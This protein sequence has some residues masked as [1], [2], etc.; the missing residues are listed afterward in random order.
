MNKFFFVCLT[1][2]V[3]SLLSSAS[4]QIITSEQAILA[5]GECIAINK[6]TDVRI[7]DNPE[8]I[9]SGQN[10]L[11]YVYSLK[12]EG[13]IVVSANINLP[14]VIAY[15]FENNFGNLLRGNPLFEMLVTDL[16]G[17]LIFVQ[18]KTGEYSEKNQIYWKQILL[19]SGSKEQ[20]EQWPATGDGWLKTNWTQ[21]APYNNMCPMDAVSA[22]R[23]IAGCPA[24]AMAQIVNFHETTNQTIFDDTDDY[25][26][27]Y[28][29]RQYF[30]DDDYFT[31][32]FPS[33][34]QLNEYLDTLNSHWVHH[35]LLDNQDKAALTFACG[36]ACK[37]VYTSS[38]SG[39]FGVDQ[40]YD[41]YLRFGFTTVELLTVTDTS[42]Y[43]RL[44]Q[45]IKDTLPGHLAVVDS[46][47][48]MGH[49]V[50]VDGYNEDGYFHIN[51]G[52]G[53]TYNGWYLLPQE[54]P[55]N[56]TVIE[57]LIVDIIPVD[58]TT[59]S[60]D[61]NSTITIYPNPASDYICVDNLNNELSG[62]EIYTTDGKLVLTQA[63]TVADISLLK[64]GTY[65]IVIKNMNQT[66]GTS[67]LTIIR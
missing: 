43:S 60:S 44:I 38:G 56:L 18:E 51:F 1:I 40:A 29:G 47:W 65:I 45:N 55:Y 26:H 48:T 6:K 42:L 67:A 21:N 15:S 14:P 46:N 36:V 39:T 23:S 4:G 11:A 3:I 54:I 34:T 8:M 66:I 12:P 32:D 57:G 61:L 20:W 58:Y 59:I 49:N 19:E 24:V 13:Y 35:L 25:Y 2:I 41:A 10:I 37:Q 16:T 5:C 28:A 53:G 64:P 31:L 50:V 52:W 27:N 30:I 33:F 9:V 63:G 7:D 22:Q 62:L 17:R